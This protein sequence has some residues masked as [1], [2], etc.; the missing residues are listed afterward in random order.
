MESK[1]LTVRHFFTEGDFVPLNGTEI[2]FQSGSTSGSEQCEQIIILNDGVREEIQE[3]FSII[4]NTTDSDVILEPETAQVLIVDNNSESH[5]LDSV[6]IMENWWVYF[7]AIAVVFD[8]MGYQR[9][10][11][12][13]VR[14]CVVLMGETNSPVEVTLSSLQDTATG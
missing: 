5:Q 7:P 12:Q 10:E 4:L 3:E 8:Q 1:N 9:V 13:N 2:V 14:V 6:I 11:G